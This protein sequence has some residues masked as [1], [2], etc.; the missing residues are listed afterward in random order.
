MRK[1]SVLTRLLLIVGLVFAFSQAGWAELPTEKELQTQLDSAKADESKKADIQN[2]EDTLALLSK[3]A[4]QKESNN[5][6]EAEISNAAKGI[7]KE[8]QALDKLKETGEQ[9]TLNFGHLSLSELQS[10][11]AQTQHSL[12][13]VQ[14]ELTS[15]NAQLINLR[16][17]PERAKNAL[18]TNLARGQE[19][20]KLLFD[21][22]ISA[23][24]KTKLETELA[25]LELQN[26]YNQTLL[27]GNN[28]LISLYSLQ[29]EDKT[30]RQQQLQKK[31]TAL[32]ETINEKNLQETQQQAEKLSQSQSNSEADNPILSEQSHINLMISQDL[33]KQTTQLNTLSQDNLRVKSVLDNLQQTERNI[34]E[35]ISALQGTLV[36]SKIINKQKQLLPQDQFISGLSK[37]ITDLRVRIFDLTELRDQLYDT[38]AY[39]GNLEKKNAISFSADEKT[40]LGTILQDRRKLVSDTITSLNNQLNLAINIELNQQQVTAISDSLQ[41]KLQQQSFWVKS[42]APID[43][44]W[45]KNF[46]T[47]VSFELKEISAQINFTNW[48]ENLVPATAL[49]TIL[50][51]VAGLIVWR[52]PNIKR[53]LSE[54]NGKVS[55]LISDSQWYTPEAVFW[56]IILCLP[57]TLVFLSALIFITFICFETPAK[58]WWWSLEMAGYWL[59]FAFMLAMLRPN[60]L[61]H[62]HFNMPQ[63]NVEIFRSVLKRSV[64]ISA[65]WLNAGMF[66]YLDSGIT[67][68]VIGQVM[69][70]SVL[71]VSLFI[72]GP[73]L[74][75][76][77][78]AYQDNQQKVGW[79][80]KFTHVSLVLAPMVL[81]SLIL[82]GYYYTA[83]NL[84]DHLIS[85]YFVF[86]AWLVFRDIIYRGFSVSSRRLAYRR[87]KEKREQ[88]KNNSNQDTGNE[89]TIDLQQDELTIAS[90]KSQ[91]LR[92]VDL[93]LWCLLIGLFSWVWADLITV[94]FYLQG[95]TLWQQSVTTD[96]GVVMESITLLNLLLAIVILLG[97]YAIV[98]NI[99]G[100]LEVLIFSR[101]N[102]SQGTPYTITTLLTYF[103]IAIGAAVAFSTLGMSWSK[104]QW[105]FAALSV[106][107]GFGLQEIFANFVSGIII[108]FER[109]VRIG[110]MVTIGNYSGTV[111]KIRIRSTTLIDSDNK[112]V[113]V[114]NKA[115]VT[116]R[117]VN[118]ALADSMTRVVIS[119]GVAYGSDVDLVK[120]L[121]LQAAN[122]SERVLKDPEPTAYFLSFG[123]STL[124]HELRVYVGKLGDRT[125]TIDFLNRRINQLFAEHNIEIAFNQLDVFI[126]NQATNEEIKVN[127]EKLN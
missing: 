73:R 72:V 95:V 99:A 2:L 104:L 6:L 33:V 112:E 46:L 17:S 37:Q 53:R 91:V 108:L 78:Q 15:I 115:F 106:G 56:T 111:S 92:M 30:L 124:D 59:F 8:Q 5:A 1:T 97:T 11:L 43:M 57:S 119:I 94:A 12:Q 29:M 100:L 68:D 24:T 7:A 71:I 98:R 74:R 26:S 54:I 23:T 27:K 48:R 13:Q 125:V 51:L 120:H 14:T 70:I 45:V 39:I 52:K 55:T 121:L 109:P 85:S 32:Q 110:D 122:E 127:S 114:P 105:L 38:S 49:I 89:I 82:M 84:M 126:K 58:Y 60:G 22:T 34:N 61:S 35:Q 10:Q 79:L 80:Y 123:A 36:L 86:V 25:L 63:Q 93:F 19:I 90:V 117:L 4:T 42:N 16:S 44:D 118:W 3:I 66:T 107:L 69:T 67:N 28:D 20:D 21:T 18:S 88:M 65:L 40:Q 96:A 81:I 50:L 101:V 41:S 116:E 76:A 102:F 103:I 83:L 77:V 9:A 47:N 31:L 113:I 64:W 62:R 75:Y 87:L